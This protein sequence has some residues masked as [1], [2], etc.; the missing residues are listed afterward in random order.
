M[1]GTLSGRFFTFRSANDSSSNYEDDIR[2]VRVEK[3]KL[4][5]LKLACVFIFKNIFI[6]F[7]RVKFMIVY[8][9][10]RTFTRT[11]YYGYAHRYNNILFDNLII[12]PP[13]NP[14]CAGAT[15]R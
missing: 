9:W 11:V 7:Q 6:F 2:R 3:S 4:E 1:A 14:P 10:E 13:N 5:I 15:A 8:S 12:L